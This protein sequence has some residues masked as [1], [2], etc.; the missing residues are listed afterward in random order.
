MRV[1]FNLNIVMTCAFFICDMLYRGKIFPISS[2]R[3]L[4]KSFAYRYMLL[5]SSSP[6]TLSMCETNNVE[7][8][9]ETIHGS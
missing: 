7:D 1:T 4:Y 9:A 2:G 8:N 3:V 6:P 5:F